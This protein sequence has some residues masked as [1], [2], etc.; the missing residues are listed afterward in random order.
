MN[1]NVDELLHYFTSLIVRQITMKYI[2]NV[3][4][5]IYKYYPFLQMC[6]CLCHKVTRYSFSN[7]SGVVRDPEADGART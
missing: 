7:S 2:K 5:K 3:N 6:T 1:Y 4:R